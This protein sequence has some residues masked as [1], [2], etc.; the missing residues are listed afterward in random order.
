MIIALKIR[1]KIEM[2]NRMAEYINT[3]NLFTD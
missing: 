3:L 2:K 1:T